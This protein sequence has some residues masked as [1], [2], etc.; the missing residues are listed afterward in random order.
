MDRDCGHCA[1]RD[2]LKEVETVE[3]KRWSKDQGPQF[4]DISFVAYVQVS[5]CSVCEGITIWKF[6]WVDEVGDAVGEQKLYP[7]QRDH[8]ALPSKIR[9]RLEAADRVRRIDPGLYAVAI[10]RLLESVFNEQGAE[11]R[12]LAAKAKD[13]A[14]KD[15]L[16]PTISIAVSHL[17]DIGKYGA[18]DEEIEVSAS[19]VPVIEDLANAVLEFIYR[20]PAAIAAL[21]ASV[22]ERGGR[23]TLGE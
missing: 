5:K 11:G 6:T 17:R 14:A 22:I 7:S 2:S 3:V 8:S 19:D 12:D 18:H 9:Q 10:R 16:P 23:I 4:G 1:N 15:Q 20:A 13:L 21:E